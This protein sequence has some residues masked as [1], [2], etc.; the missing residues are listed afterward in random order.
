MGSSVGSRIVT[1]RYVC[2]NTTDMDI[3]LPFTP[4]RVTLINDTSLYQ[5]MW[6]EA[7]DPDS[8]FETTD[9][10]TTSLETSD[11]I[12]AHLKFNTDD[13]S[14]TIRGFTL[15]QRTNVND[16]ADEVIHWVAYE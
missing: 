10:G 15:G 4:S 7:M 8:G 2:V 1:G 12:T 5:V 9:T 3:E 6:Q 16:A 13:S 14:P 11:L